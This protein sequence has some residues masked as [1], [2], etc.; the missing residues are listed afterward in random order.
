[1][2]I[3]TSLRTFGFVVAFG[4]I[5]SVS[6][7]QFK[8]DTIKFGGSSGNNYVP[9]TLTVHVG[10]TIRFKGA[11][12]QHP[13]ITDEV[14]TGATKFDHDAGAILSYIVTVPGVYNYHCSF[15]GQNDGT[16][17]AGTFTAVELG[18]HSKTLTNTTATNYPNPFTDKITIQLSLKEQAQGTI[19]VCDLSGNTVGTVFE[20][21]IAAGTQEYVFDGSA[22][23][24]GTYFY[25]LTTVEGTLVKQII[26]VA[27]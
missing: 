14:P 11:F 13:L 21:L 4:F 16:G 8:A 24:S 7:G 3:S 26:K 17:M 18:V 12:A 1:M 19:S 10:D 27:R 5:A 9:K 15:H 23:S 6:F 22:F 20:G 2:N 25:K